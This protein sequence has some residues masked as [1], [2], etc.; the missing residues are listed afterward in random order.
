MAGRSRDHLGEM[1][2]PR[3]R[4]VD[5]WNDSCTPVDGMRSLAP[6]GVLLALCVAASGCGGTTATSTSAGTMSGY[7]KGFTGIVPAERRTTWNPGL[8]AAGGIPR[9]TAICQTLVPGGGDDTAAIQAALDVCPDNQVVKLGPGDFHISGEGL[10]I[11][12]SSITLRGSGTS[13]R[14]VKIDQATR[15]FPVV[16]LGNRWSTAK[17]VSST[18]LATNGIKG[19]RTVRLGA[20]PSP[21]LTVGEIVYLDQLTDPGL[22][23]WGDRSPPGDASRRW[24]TRMDRPLT[25]MVEVDSVDGTAVTF[26]TPLH[27]DFATA[28]SAQLSR[29]GEGWVRPATRWSGVED[30]YL[31]GGSGGDGGGNIALFVCA[32]CWVKGVESAHSLGTS[33]N[34][35]GCFRCEVRDSYV[36]TSD[37]P[38]P[39]GDGYLLG[40]NMG[41]ADNLV[42]NNVVWNG[43][44]MIVMRATGGG[45]VIAYNYLDDG[46]GAEYP[47]LVEVG[48]NASHMTTS[49]M[50]LFEGNQCFNFDSDDYWGNA[51]DITVFRNHFTGR[52][53]NADNLGLED[54]YNRRAVGLTKWSLWYTFA[55]NV[56]GAP[57]QASIRPQTELVYEAVPGLGSRSGFD[58][59]KYGYMWKLGY[60]GEDS[61]APRDEQVLS[62]LIR[63]G[64]FD[65]VTGRVAW[66]P[67]NPNHDLPP[68]LYL[69]S[70]P[71]FFGRLPWPWVDPAGARP[72]Q[73]LPARARFDAGTPMAFSAGS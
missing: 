13:T 53:R 58:D 46:Y 29:Y 70:K 63:H 25:Q 5:A 42:E 67:G 30:L 11:T 8:N 71:A 12:R 47:G 18:D 45:N 28:F 16:I 59:D 27:I 51:I 20:V 43:N 4:G 37:N 60:T 41:S 24:F 40:L 19:S 2:D 15:A 9:R 36:H 35:A 52:R 32:Y 7:P 33:V 10:S 69:A 61:A 65:Y 49:H 26:T 22:T 57:G 31:E 1:H 34:L 73:T 39:G 64:N 66:D 68:S 17:F 56:L 38:N 23:H 44:K 62:T 72:L 54:A 48:L 50:E 14:L 21:P 6:P 3:P 55:G